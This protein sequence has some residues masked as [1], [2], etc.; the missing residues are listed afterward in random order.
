M[1]G[2]SREKA[3]LPEAPSCPALGGAGEPRAEGGLV[4]GDLILEPPVACRRRLRLR[5]EAGQRAERS[6][7]MVGR[8]AHAK[9]GWGNCATRPG[10]RGKQEK[11]CEPRKMLR[12]A[13]DGKSD[14]I[15][16]EATEITEGR[17]EIGY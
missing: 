1:A 10:C 15:L 14:P 4:G 3:V 13:K 2:G 11:V 8:R 7:M 16:Q 5:A 17:P 12:C 6:G 9:R